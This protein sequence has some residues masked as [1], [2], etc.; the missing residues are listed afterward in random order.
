MSSIRFFKEA[1]EYL[2]MQSLVGDKYDGK[3]LFVLFLNHKNE[4]VCFHI[5]HFT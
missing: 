1:A 2:M 5:F 3:Y 4:K